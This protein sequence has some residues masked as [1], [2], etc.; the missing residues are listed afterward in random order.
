MTDLIY[1]WRLETA[2]KCCRDLC[3]RM[4]IGKLCLLVAEVSPAQLEFSTAFASRLLVQ[5]DSI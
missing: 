3:R 1:E 4:N 5:V 2:D